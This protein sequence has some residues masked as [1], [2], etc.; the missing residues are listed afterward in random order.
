MIEDFAI[1]CVPQSQIKWKT[2]KTRN[3]KPFF[4]AARDVFVTQAL[5]SSL[6]P[7]SFSIEANQSDEGWSLHWFCADH[8]GIF[9][10]DLGTYPNRDAAKL[11]TLRFLSALVGLKW[12]GEFV[13][14]ALPEVKADDSFFGGTAYN[15]QRR[16]WKK[17]YFWL[18]SKS[19]S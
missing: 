17:K 7:S 11:F 13:V 14:L 5:S 19:G 2:G 6:S 9:E 10:R 3:G 18:F 4:S 8:G 16:E 12:N 1:Y 15:N